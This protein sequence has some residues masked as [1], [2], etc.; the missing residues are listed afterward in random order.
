MK[1]GPTNRL[2]VAALSLGSTLILLACGGGG[3]QTPTSPLTP[4]APASITPSTTLAAETGNNTSAADSFVAQS[5][6]NA[7][8]T[9]VSK[10]PVRS[11]LYPG[12]TTKI[13][14]HLVAWFGGS[15]HMNVGY[16]SADPSQ[17]HRQVEDM[18]SRG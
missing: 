9:N 5:N 12:S 1:F 3:S 13:Y 7:G 15:G 18:I 17:V 4:P 10:L 8:A 6:G 11:L 14:A 2:L 16:N